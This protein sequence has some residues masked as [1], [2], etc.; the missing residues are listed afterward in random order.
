MAANGI[1]VVADARRK[2]VRTTIPD[3]TAP[4]L[5]DLVR[6]DFS[7][8]EPGARTCRDIT[9]IPTGEGFL[10][11][12][13]VLDLGVRRLVGFA[14]GERMPWELC[15]DAIDVATAHRFGEVAGMVFHHD[16]A[17]VFVKPRSD[18]LGCANRAA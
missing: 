9:Y 15:R 4:P 3:V 1:V 13:S 16:Y 12:A 17:E 8:G 10:Y 11:L 7:L 5:P 14:I 6:R 18:R 2:K